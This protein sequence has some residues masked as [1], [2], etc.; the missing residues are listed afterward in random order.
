MEEKRRDSRYSQDE[1][2][3][4]F[5]PEAAKISQTERAELKR[6]K[7]SFGRAEG[8]SPSA[9]IFSPV[10]PPPKEPLPPS[11]KIP[12]P[13][14]PEIPGIASFERRFP[15]EFSAETLSQLILD[16]WT[17][18]YR[19]EFPD[20]AAALM[21]VSK[22]MGELIEL[23]ALP[24][25]DPCREEHIA[26]DL[27]ILDRCFSEMKL[28]SAILLRSADDLGLSGAFAEKKMRE[29]AFLFLRDFFTARG[30]TDPLIPPHPKMREALSEAL[31]RGVQLF[32]P[33]AE[34]QSTVRVL[35]RALQVKDAL[36]RAARLL[37]EKKSQRK[38][39]KA[40]FL[41]KEM[42]DSGK[43]IAFADMIVPCIAMGQ[44]RIAMVLL[45]YF[46][47][48]L[49]ESEKRSVCLSIFLDRLMKNSSQE[50]N[51]ALQ[52]IGH[53]LKRMS[54]IETIARDETYQHEL[55]T[56][57]D[58][59]SSDQE[60]S[61][62]NGDTAP[63]KNLMFAPPSLSQRRQFLEVLEGKDNKVD[64]YLELSI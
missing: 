7:D 49:K 48:T 41:L 3:R 47:E 51:K 63:E 27:L 56:A 6:L 10:L 38:K 28:L 17:K 23:Y 50:A 59:L 33:P 11:V 58:Q 15:Q 13:V 2:W 9:P 12:D 30:I 62:T 20:E 1:K 16:N 19:A 55:E 39:E 4:I 36:S 5:E 8:N 44:S 14:F 61:P 24:E 57:F 25:E 52:I 29:T 18:T 45:F 34:A 54:L 32:L 53:L 43:S 60:T 26:L 21:I 46:F 42:D 64:S 35:I 22:K 40:L 37:P 31:F